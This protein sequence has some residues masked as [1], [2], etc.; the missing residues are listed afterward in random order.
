MSGASSQFGYT[1]DGMVF[2]QIN[3]DQ[4]GKK[5]HTFLSLSPQAAREFAAHLVSNASLAEGVKNGG[6]G[7]T[8]N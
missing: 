5:E 7:A 6:N 2:V 8:V 1:P 3:F 4:N